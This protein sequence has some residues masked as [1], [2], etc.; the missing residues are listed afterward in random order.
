MLVEVLYNGGLSRIHGPSLLKVL[1]RSRM[2]S[3][4]GRS[5]G[6]ALET[7]EGRLVRRLRPRNRQSAGRLSW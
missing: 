7:W 2:M 4:L 1:V 3:V 6:R 5:I